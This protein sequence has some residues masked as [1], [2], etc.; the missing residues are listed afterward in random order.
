MLNVL[1][2]WLG[3]CLTLTATIVLQNL[4]SIQITVVH[5]EVSDPTYTIPTGL[6]R[7][8]QLIHQREGFGGAGLGNCLAAPQIAAVTRSSVHVVVERGHR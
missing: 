4:A 7:L 2:V 8:R 3:G 1:M 5:S 6:L